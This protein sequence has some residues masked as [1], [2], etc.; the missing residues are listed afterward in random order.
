MK[1]KLDNPEQY[2]KIAEI[3]MDAIYDLFEKRDKEFQNCNSVLPE[4]PDKYMINKL[5]LKIREI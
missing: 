2:Y 3:D 5:L 1:V 4:E